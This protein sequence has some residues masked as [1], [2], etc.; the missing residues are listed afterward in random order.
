MSLR[1]RSVANFQPSICMLSPYICLHYCLRLQHIACS[2]ATQ[3]SRCRITQMVA[4]QL[5]SVVVCTGWSLWGAAHV[6]LSGLGHLQLPV[7]CLG[8][9]VQHLYSLPTLFC[10]GSLCH[11]PSLL[12]EVPCQATPCSGEPMRCLTPL[13][14]THMLSW[15]HTVLLCLAQFVSARLQYWL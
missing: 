14:Y 11:H 9:Q 3:A 7:W 5:L 8:V 15:L 1:T 6:C 13:T 2:G 10:A 4:H 12:S